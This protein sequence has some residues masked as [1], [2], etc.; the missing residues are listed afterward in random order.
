[1]LAADSFSHQR[2]EHCSWGTQEDFLNGMGLSVDEGMEGAQWLQGRCPG[3]GTSYLL[4]AGVGLP[5]LTTLN[6]PVGSAEAVAPGEV[7]SGVIQQ[8][9]LLDDL[10]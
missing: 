1:M 6:P 2:L 8:Q 9:P 4:A 10:E 5:G 3:R 7:A